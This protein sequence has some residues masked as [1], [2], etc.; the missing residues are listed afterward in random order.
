MNHLGEKCA[1]QI[2]QIDNHTSLGCFI[3]L[4]LAQSFYM[5]PLSSQVAQ[6]AFATGIPTP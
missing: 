2:N 3:V 6:L 1:N 5:V 4:I